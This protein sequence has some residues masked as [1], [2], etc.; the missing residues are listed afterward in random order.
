MDINVDD[1]SY[2]HFYHRND[3]HKKN[4][5][6]KCSIR[7]TSNK[8]SEGKEGGRGLHCV[9]VSCQMITEVVADVRAM[10]IL[11]DENVRK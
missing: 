9:H 5:V 3:T 11:E 8:T 1:Y 2:F 4:L 10:M 6:S 7:D